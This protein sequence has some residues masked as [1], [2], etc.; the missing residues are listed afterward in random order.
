MATCKYCG[1][2]TGGTPFCQNCGAKVDA[3]LVVPQPVPVMNQPAYQPMPMQA[4]VASTPY[5]YT[6]GGAGGLLA[7]NI[8]MLILSVI[9][10]CLVFTLI[11]L[12]LSIVGIVFAAKVKN[13]QNAEQEKSYR[14]VALIMLLISIA[15]LVFSIVIFVIG[16]YQQYGGWDGFWEAIESVWESA[17]EEAKSRLF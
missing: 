15:V 4:P 12:A 16:V 7:G 13:A 2:E 6:P 3:E 10:C 14:R 11:A 17:Q 8:I 5:F 1:N 9:T